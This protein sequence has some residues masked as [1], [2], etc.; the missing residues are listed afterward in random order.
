MSTN[1]LQNCWILDG[2]LDFDFHVVESDMILFNLQKEF[3]SEAFEKL[4]RKV[5]STDAGKVL[6]YFAID[7]DLSWESSF[8][9]QDSS[10]HDPVVSSEVVDV[11]HELF[12]DQVVPVDGSFAAIAANIE[13]WIRIS[14]SASKPHLDRI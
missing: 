5:P 11:Y 10:W 8:R 4:V 1:L 12:Q 9:S 2:R 6:V 14:S 13:S 7:L 3:A